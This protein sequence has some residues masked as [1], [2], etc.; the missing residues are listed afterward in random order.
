M[1]V[2]IVSPLKDKAAQEMY[3]KFTLEGYCPFGP[4][5]MTMGFIADARKGDDGYVLKVEVVDAAAFEYMK[6][7]E[8][9]LER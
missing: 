5:E 9:M 6:E 8:R 7:L 4:E 1:Y 2:R 3:E